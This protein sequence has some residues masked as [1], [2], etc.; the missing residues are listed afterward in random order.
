[1]SQR[2]SEY[3][4]KER[5]DYPTLPWVT[6]T[7]IPHLKALG[8]TSIWDPAAG[9]GQIVATLRQ[10]GF[11]A[12]GTDIIDGN[13]FLNGCMPTTTC[14]AI[15]SNPPYGKGGR[16]ALQF[17]ERSLELT[18][19]GLGVASSNLAAPT[20]KIKDLDGNFEISRQDLPQKT[21][22][23]RPGKTKL[24]HEQNFA[25]PLSVSLYR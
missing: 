8:A 22:L 19:P 25:P 10:H 13:D 21:V 1:M 2:F 4:R 17:I 6:E 24:K 15:V 9:N 5:D 7:V 16:M 20:S 14:N 11:D 18:R 23:E 3:A 12:V